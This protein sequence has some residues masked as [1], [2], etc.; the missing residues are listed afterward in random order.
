MMIGES[1][2]V[3]NIRIVNAHPFLCA[4]WPG[5]NLGGISH[6][7]R[8]AWYFHSKFWWWSVDKETSRTG[9][10]SNGAIGGYHCGGA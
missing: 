3:V 6:E 8:M 1:R 9:L 2:L 4:V 10:C 5:L 7:S